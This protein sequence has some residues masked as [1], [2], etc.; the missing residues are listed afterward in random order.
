M[1][2]VWFR[3]LCL[4]FRIMCLGFGVQSHEVRVWEVQLRG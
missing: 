3:V 4:G 2:L 1:S